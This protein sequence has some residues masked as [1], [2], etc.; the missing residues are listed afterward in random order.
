M[1]NICL[2]AC[3]WIYPCRLMPINLRS[4]F[5]L[6]RV[7]SFI[8]YAANG[9]EEALINRGRHPFTNGAIY[10]QRHVKATVT[11]ERASDG[12]SVMRNHKDE[13]KTRCTH[14]GRQLEAIIIK[15]FVHATI[16]F[17]CT[18]MCIEQSY[19]KGDLWHRSRARFFYFLIH[20]SE[21]IFQKE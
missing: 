3:K 11:V 18:R 6:F 13:R 21:E 1:K 2:F 8:D 4:E 16:V 10:Y 9:L 17:L 12:F 7:I 14:P 5:N 15:Y 19:I 20:F